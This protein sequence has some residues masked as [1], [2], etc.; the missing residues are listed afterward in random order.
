MGH[1]PHPTAK[2]NQL[3]NNE[4]TVEVSKEDLRQLHIAAMA[5]RNKSFALRKALD[6]IEPIV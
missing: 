5:K 2:P 6:N 3:Q 1:K 4:D